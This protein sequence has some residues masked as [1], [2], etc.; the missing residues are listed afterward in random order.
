VDGAARRAARARLG[1]PE[2]AFV[3]GSF[4]KDG[5]GM[6][7]GLEPKLVKGPDVLLDALSRLR[8]RVPQ[9]QLLLSAPARGYV[10]AGLERLGVP[11]RHA[12]V[13]AYRELSPL[14]H[15]CDV[16]LAASRQEGGPKSVLE[17]MASGVP[18]VTTRVGQAGELVSHGENGFLV[19]VEDAEGLAR[20]TERVHSGGLE[21]EQVVAAARR[22]AEANAY[23]EQ[24]PLW[25][26]FMRGFVAL[27][28]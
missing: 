16:C 12:P 11:Y 26:E 9:L 19:E 20:W 17:A 23:A 28:E 27:P 21:L 8:G 13:R 3:V 18:V 5:V 24:T 2:T 6:G 15:A 14:Y 22:T 1:L 25:R 7:E 10:K 4:S